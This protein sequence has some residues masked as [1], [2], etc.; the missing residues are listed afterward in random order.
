MRE[1]YSLDC[2]IEYGTEP[3]PDAISVVNPARRQLDSQIRSQAMNAA[4]DV[5]ANEA[6]TNSCSAAPLLRQ[7]RPSG[8]SFLL[9]GS[10]SVFVVACN[11]F[12]EWT[13]LIV[14]AS[15]AAGARAFSNRGAA[16]AEASLYGYF[17]F[18][19]SN[20]IAVLRIFRVRPQVQRNDGLNQGQLKP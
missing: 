18:P 7:I 1:H 19:G 10:G 15:G 5:S 8:I 17:Y 13:F 6:T 20:S 9:P 14:L 2:L 16:A 11:C 4:P 12:G 3:I